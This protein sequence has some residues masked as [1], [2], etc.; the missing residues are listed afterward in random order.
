MEWKVRVDC[1]YGAFSFT[2]GPIKPKYFEM[3]IRYTPLMQIYNLRRLQFGKIGAK[4]LAVGALQN[5]AIPFLY[6]K[7]CMPTFVPIV[8]IFY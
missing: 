2:T 8:P 5:L 7:V 1:N 6:N 3:A 4:H